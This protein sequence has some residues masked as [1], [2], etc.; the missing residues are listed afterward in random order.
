[1]PYVAYLNAK[2]VELIKYKH[3]FHKITEETKEAPKPTQ[4]EEL[5]SKI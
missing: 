4:R 3:R 5:A 2:K 1:V